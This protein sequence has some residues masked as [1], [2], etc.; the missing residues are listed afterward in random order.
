[1]QLL[2]ELFFLG[3]QIVLK[4]PIENLANTHPKEKD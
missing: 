2:I 3:V 4:T 1:M